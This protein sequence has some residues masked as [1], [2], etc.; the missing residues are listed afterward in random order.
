MLHHFK[1]ALFKA[2]AHP[3]RIQ[4]LDLLRTGERSVT[5]LQAELQV[6]A[7][8]VSQQLAIL[9][10]KNLVAPRKDGTSVYYRVADP[11]VFTLLDVARAMFE[12]HVTGLQ[13]LI[14]DPDDQPAS[15][16]GDSSDAPARAETAEPTR[17]R[18]KSRRRA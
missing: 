17:D 12:T 10:G 9:R 6:E 11:Q 3:T 2:L 15:S 7:S 1:A 8:T 5:D 13:S 4:I 14:T 18:A 16:S